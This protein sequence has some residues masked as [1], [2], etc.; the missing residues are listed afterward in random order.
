[1]SE[2]Q[3]SKELIK[4]AVETISKAKAVSATQN[5]EKNE[6][7]KTFSDAK[8]GKI[9]TIEFK[10]AVHSLFEAD[11]YLYKYAPNHDL[12]EEKAK[13][14]SKLLFDAQKHINNVLGGFGFDFETVALD[15]QALYIVSNKKVL[16]SLKDI[17]PDLNII[18][19]EGVL[20]IE[21]MKVVNP[22]IPE[23]AL[24]GIEKKCKITKEQISK[25]ISNISPS[26]VVVLVKDGDI[27]DEL[28]YE[29][30]K[31]LYNAEKLNADEIL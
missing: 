18:S 24:L 26:K 5:F 6:N 7:K 3:Y 8:S 29:R 12:D 10:K 14:F 2:T 9:D 27:A 28:I 15:G 17:N 25:V 16:K 21:D 30:A 4:K 20:E 23:K 13:E 19:T 11:E 31:E 22:K 1:M